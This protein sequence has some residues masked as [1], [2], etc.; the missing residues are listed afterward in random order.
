M[1]IS[2]TKMNKPTPKK[3]FNLFDDDMSSDDDAPPRAPTKQLPRYIDTATSSVPTQPYASLADAENY[4]TKNFS[5]KPS[6]APESKPPNVKMLLLNI[7][8]MT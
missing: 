5:A 4:M 8:M 7:L 6:N 3:G 1:F 2:T